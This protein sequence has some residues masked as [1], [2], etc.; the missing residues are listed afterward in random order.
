MKEIILK[1]GSVTFVDDDIYETQKHY[2]WRSFQGY[3]VRYTSIKG[4]NTIV[5]LHRFIMGQPPKGFVVDHIDGCRSNNLRSNL[6]FATYSQN[7]QNQ[8]KKSKNKTSIY[9][10]VFWDKSQNRWI[11]EVTL[12]GKGQRFGQYK[13][14]VEA[15]VAYNSAAIQL[16]G[17]YASLNTIQGY[18]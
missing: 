15:A 10:G 11:A 16:F 1:E 8:T 12:H 13:S 18:V 9:K 7:K 14:E 5:Y 6:R 2:T 3:T 4:K 17:E